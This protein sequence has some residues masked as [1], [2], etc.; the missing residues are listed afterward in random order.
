MP[1]DKLNIAIIG[2]SGGLGKA[3]IN[4]LANRQDVENIYAFARSDIS[5]AIDKVTFANI[6]L[7][8]EDTIQAAAELTTDTGPLDLVIV[9][10]GILHTD[11]LSP[12]KSI[13]DLTSQKMHEVYQINTVG[14]ALVGKYFIPKLAKHS[15][16]VFAALSAR[17]GSIQDNLYGGW[18]AYRASKAALNMVVRNFSIELG[19]MHKQMIFVSLH[20]GTVDTK[21][22][23]PYQ[24]SA[25]KDQIFSPEYSA[26]KLLQVIDNLNFEDSGSFLA[27][28]GKKINF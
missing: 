6:D 3:F 21:L 9:A 23:K 1:I 14:P 20:P 18:Y 10:T 17:V 5:F 12:E 11:N 16:A 28:D 22:S 19:R 2:A 7:T 15:R 4:E 26:Q 8:F 24:K 27:W 13:R 25:G